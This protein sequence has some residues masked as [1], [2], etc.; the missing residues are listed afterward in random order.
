MGDWIG[1]DWIGI[2]IGIGIGWIGLVLS[3]LDWIGLDWIGIGIGWIGLDWIGI[4][5]IGLDWIGLV[6]VL[7]GLDWIGLVLG[8]LDW[9]G[10]DWYWVDWIGLD[11]IGLVLVLVLGAS[12]SLGV[13]A[14]VG[15]ENK[16]A[17]FLKNYIYFKVITIIQYYYNISP[18][19][20][21]SSSLDFLILLSSTCFLCFKYIYIYIYFQYTGYPC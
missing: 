11:W 19:L 3:G 14:S 18:T 8:G 15:A 7:G 4:G 21:L 16:N 5:W 13:G 9:I 10:L 20:T 17:F 1:L 6:L 2:S 12:A